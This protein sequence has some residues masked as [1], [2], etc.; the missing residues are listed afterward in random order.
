MQWGVFGL[1]KG[2]FPF[3]LIKTSNVI[4]KSIRNRDRFGQDASRIKS[5]NNKFTAGIAMDG[6]QRQVND[7]NQKVDQLH[8]IVERLS[9]QI[10]TLTTYEE[11]TA[12]VSQ[13]RQP[14]AVSDM[15][16]RSSSSVSYD[17][18]LI[19]DRSHWG[20]ETANA[21]NGSGRYRA[22]LEHKDILV[23]EAEIQ[24]VTPP[25]TE[26]LLSTDIQIRRLTAQLTAAYNRIATLEEQ[27]LACR[28]HT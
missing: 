17:Y 16:L 6:L 2:F 11:E 4:V 9:G 24:P 21:S 25:T 22:T 13:P 5:R 7:L 19:S 27:L 28:M 8:Q 15:D 14:M 3:R 26:P 20:Y 10:T 1:N 23:E 12:V 18:N